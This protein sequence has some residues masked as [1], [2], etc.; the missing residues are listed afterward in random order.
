MEPGH[1][2]RRRRRGGGG[3]CAPRPG[4]LLR[5]LG[6]RLADSLHRARDREL[7]DHRWRRWVAHPPCPYRH[8]CAARVCCGARSARGL[9][10]RP[11]DNAAMRDEAAPA[12]IEARGWGLRH[13][14]RREWALRG[15][16]LVVEAGERVLLLGPSGA[17]KSTLLTA[18]A[19]L[20]DPAGGAEVEGELLVDGLDPR[21]ARDRTGLLFQ[22]PESQI[23][24]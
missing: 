7:G 11:D 14:G 16:D 5:G 15:L 17:G 1:G 3:R 13:P 10:S 24:M 22:D 6:S 21:E 20:I 8:W 19:G 23:V 4:L 18:I 2:G 12:R 9:I